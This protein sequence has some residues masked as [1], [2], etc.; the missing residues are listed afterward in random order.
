MLFIGSNNHITYIE[1]CQKIKFDLHSLSK[2]ET[3]DTLESSRSLKNNPF[4][5]KNDIFNKKVKTD[6]DEEFDMIK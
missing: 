4:L 1:S 2:K 3:I 5:T 6:K